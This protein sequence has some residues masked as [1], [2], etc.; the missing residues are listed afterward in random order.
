M[1]PMGRD[2][3]QNVPVTPNDPDPDFSMSR[4][5]SLGG[6]PVS[7]PST[8]S[9]STK[10]PIMKSK[11]AIPEGSKRESK[12]ISMYFSVV[13]PTSGDSPKGQFGLNHDYNDTQALQ[14]WLY[15]FT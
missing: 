3:L 4:R 15:P 10:T 1:D 13:Y 11:T 2:I 7:K 8:V 12:E 5:I 6:C 14:S 9:I